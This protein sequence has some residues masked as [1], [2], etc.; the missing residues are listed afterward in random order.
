MRHRIVWLPG[1]AGEAIYLTN[2]VAQRVTDTDGTVFAR[3]PIYANGRNASY[4][5]ITLNSG[6]GF[7][8]MSSWFT[9]CENPGIPIAVE[10]HFD[11]HLLHPFVRRL[12]PGVIGVG[13]RLV[14]KPHGFP[15]VFIG[16]G[17]L[18]RRQLLLRPLDLDGRTH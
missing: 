2:V 13:Q 1:A 15:I 10:A 5:W 14:G 8:R 6:E 4:A 11:G 18:G 3:G 7:W 9:V 16:R 17:S 12:G